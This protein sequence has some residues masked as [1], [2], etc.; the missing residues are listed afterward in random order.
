VV[1]KLAFGRDTPRSRLDLVI[2]IVSAAALGLTKPI[3]FPLVLLV[4]AI[5]AHRLPVRHSRLVVL[6]VLAAAVAA[7]TAALVIA[8]PSINAIAYSAELRL[9][10]VFSRPFHVAEIIVTELVVH[11]PR[12][13]AQFIGK[14]GWLDTRLPALLILTY[15]AV[16]LAAATLDTG[17]SVVVKPWQRV[18]FAAAVAGSIGALGVAMYVFMG[19]MEGIQGRYFHP[20]ALA[21]AWIVFTDRFR[22][23][24]LDLRIGPI[25]AALTTASVLVSLMTL[26][27]RYYG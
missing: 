27:H 3:Y 11:S 20:M 18:V 2:V 19:R 26:H 15:F 16:L 7:V 9:D 13:A 24:D 8:R 23:A 4:L 12:Y 17:G 14:L 22:R 1:A 5:P 6:A 21:A 10:D 25:V